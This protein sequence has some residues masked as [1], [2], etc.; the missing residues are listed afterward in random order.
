MPNKTMMPE[1]VEKWFIQQIPMFGSHV[2]SL[3][4]Y[5][6]CSLACRCLQ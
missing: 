5:S 2:V 6:I 1:V 4:E 3:N